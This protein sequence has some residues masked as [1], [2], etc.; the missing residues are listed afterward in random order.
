MKNLVTALVLAAFALTGAGSAHAAPSADARTA[1]AKAFINDV[2]TQAL[3][4]IKA[5]QEGKIADTAAKEKFRSLLSSSF[6]LQTIAR[7]TLGRYWRVATPAQQKEFTQLLK[8]VIID[9][10]AD[11]MLTASTGDFTI[12]NAQSI[13]DK[14]TAVM[15]NI[16]PTDGEPISFAW[17]VRT[18]GKT[19]KIIDLAVE[20][21]SMSITHRADFASVI[22]RNGGSIQALIDALK[23][24]L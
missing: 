10:Y 14:D 24:K 11:R 12:S 4:T 2:G 1:Q 22:E 8:D 20:G 18:V 17:R 21:V 9:K 13:N 19:P 3:D 6:D 5:T 23:A 15:M 7:F 16:K